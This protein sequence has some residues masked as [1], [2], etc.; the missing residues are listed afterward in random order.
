M[1]VLAFIKQEN[2]TFQK[3]LK[4]RKLLP[5]EKFGNFLG[6]DKQSNRKLL[7]LISVD[8]FIKNNLY[9]FRVEISFMPKWKIFRF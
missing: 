2:L 9:D 3:L 8:S 5:A 7:S 1:A 4:N 6:L